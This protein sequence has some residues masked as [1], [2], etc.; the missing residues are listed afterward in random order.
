M[1]NIIV[2]GFFLPRKNLASWKLRMSPASG[3]LWSIS[4]RVLVY[5]GFSP[6]HKASP[7][8]LLLTREQ[9]MTDHV[10]LFWSQSTYTV[11]LCTGATQKHIQKVLYI[12]TSCFF[13]RE[14]YKQLPRGQTE[15]LGC[16]AILDFF[17]KFKRLQRAVLFLNLSVWRRFRFQSLVPPTEFDK[18]LWISCLTLS[19]QKNS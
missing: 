15:T 2:W 14:E 1:S 17:R 6:G 11:Y 18:P 4:I 8:W 19:G 5:S 7:R 12:E 16:E 9:C 13:H 10:R 3:C